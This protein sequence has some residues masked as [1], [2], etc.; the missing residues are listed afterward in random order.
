MNARLLEALGILLVRDIKRRIRR[1]EIK[2]PSKS[3]GTTLVQSSK[4]INSIRHKVV[5]EKVVVGSGLN[6]ARIH[7][8]GGIIRPVNAK[9][10]AIPIAKIAAAKKPREF[11]NTFIKKGII[12]QKQEDG[13]LLALYALKKQVSIPARPYMN[14]DPNARAQ[15]RQML[16]QYMEKTFKE[17]S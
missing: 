13:S 2:P 4:L 1:N 12:F 9:A 15:M 17:R 16:I 5:G 6:Y 7:H 8:E 11:D 3:S 10:L 14:I